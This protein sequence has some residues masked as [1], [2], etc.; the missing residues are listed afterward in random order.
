[1]ETALFLDRMTP[2]LPDPGFCLRLIFLGLCTAIGTG[3]LIPGLILAYNGWKEQRMD[4]TIPGAIILPTAIVCFI[5]A[6]YLFVRWT[7][8]QLYIYQRVRQDDDRNL[9][10]E[11]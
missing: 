2:H 3:L 11:S 4:A 8:Q 5:C 6:C 10:M 7:R 9:E 1:M